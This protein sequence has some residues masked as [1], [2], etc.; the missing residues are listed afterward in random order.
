M[1][2]KLTFVALICAI[3][4]LTS[5]NSIAQ[6][7]TGLDKSPLDLAYFP[8]SS[9]YKKDVKP[10]MRVMYSRPQKKG[11]K[12]FGGLEAYDKVWRA[13]ANEA[14]E[15]IF[16]EDVKLGGKDIKA[17]TYTLYVI[18]TADHWTVI[19]SKDTNVWGAYSYDQAMDVTRI[20]VKTQKTPSA[21]EAFTIMFEGKGPKG[22]M[23][24]AWDDTMV[25][26]PI[27]K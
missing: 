9:G 6:K 17:G 23:L 15:V 16:F 4:G 8:Q 3:V 25:E 22:K 21:V 7:F 24:M 27:N 2:L 5:T 14:T 13:G 1:K 20:E 12:V 26:I 10:V 19:L 18:P 11:R